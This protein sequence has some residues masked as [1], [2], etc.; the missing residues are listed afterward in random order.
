MIVQRRDA[1]EPEIVAALRA[2]GCWV[3]QMDRTAG[4]DLLVR[5]DGKSWVM[6]VKRPKHEKELTNNEYN[7]K[8]NMELCDC[9][10]YV[11]S[12]IEYA[13]EIIGTR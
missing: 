7:V 8:A 13:L 3:G 12:N 5:R 6:E 11:V 2:A 1:N 10:Y 9:E 4:F